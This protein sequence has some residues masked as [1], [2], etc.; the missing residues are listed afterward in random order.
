MLGAAMSAQVAIASQEGMADPRTTVREGFSKRTLRWIAKGMV[1]SDFLWQSLG[2]GLAR[3]GLYV[4][5][6]REEHD[7][8]RVI[9]ENPCIK[10]ALDKECVLSGPFADMQ[11]SGVA[12]V[13][14]SHLPKLFGTYE[15]ELHATIKSLAQQS[16]DAIINIGSA[17]GY[18]AVGL[19]R[20][21]RDI[22]ILAFDPDPRANA[23][24][25]KLAGLNGV[26]DRLEVRGACDAEAIL[27]LPVSNALVVIDCEGA[28]SSL[29]T[30]AVARHLKHCTLI[31]ETHDGVSPGVTTRLRDTLH[32]THRADVIEAVHD[33]DRADA[34]HGPALLKDL[35]RSEINLLLAE[36]R[37]HA[38]LR[39]LVSF[40][41]SR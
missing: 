32:A 18:Y 31:I 25:R 15:F 3:F 33:S 41:R 27:R 4:A 12:S 40:P 22:P 39:W 37:M 6:Q 21:F 11:Y 9:R 14:S 16:F 35:T 29:I 7:R 5:A 2:Q 38:C 13:C 24:I 36:R 20:I 1:A 28:E 23:N 19:G 10:R 30:P 26:A 17:E 8:L 34:I